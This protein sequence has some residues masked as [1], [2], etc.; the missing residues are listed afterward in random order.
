[1]PT[2]SAGLLKKLLT[3]V[4]SLKDKLSAKVSDS[5]KEVVSGSCEGKDSHNHLR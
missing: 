3:P 1:M 2:S 5:N 4:K